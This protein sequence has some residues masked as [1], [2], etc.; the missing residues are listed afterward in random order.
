MLCGAGTGGFCLI[1]VG[2]A[3]CTRTDRHGMIRASTWVTTPIHGGT[4]FTLARFLPDPPFGIGAKD[5]AHHCIARPVRK[6]TGKAP[7]K[8]GTGGNGAGGHWD[9]LHLAFLPAAQP[10]NGK[11]PPALDMAHAI[12]LALFS[13]RTF[14]RRHP[15]KCLNLKTSKSQLHLVRNSILKNLKTMAIWP[16][17]PR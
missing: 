17:A 14:G 6:T 3:A 15:C 11:K 4:Q 10:T 13:S 8:P 12:Y 9:W 16:I 1:S 2:C 5:E 7:D